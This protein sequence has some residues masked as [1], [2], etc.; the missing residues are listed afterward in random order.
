RFGTILTYT[1]YIDWKSFISDKLAEDLEMKAEAVESVVPRGV[2]TSHSTIP[3]LFSKPVWSGTRDDRKMPPR[4]TTTAFR[5]TPSTPGR[6]GPGRTSS[7]PPGSTSS[8][9]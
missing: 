1:D 5:S 2:V 9:Q 3:G 6:S 8:A 7:A 4:S